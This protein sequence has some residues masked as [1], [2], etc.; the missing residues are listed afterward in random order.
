MLIFLTLVAAGV[1]TAT[2]EPVALLAVVVLIALLLRS[3][4]RRVGARRLAVAAALLAV[5]VAPGAYG[6]AARAGLLEL[7]LALGLTGGTLW[8]LGLRYLIHR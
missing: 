1:L 2:G 5:V 7:A 4:G 3:Y 6:L 8:L